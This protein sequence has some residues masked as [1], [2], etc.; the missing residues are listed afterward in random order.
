MI[1]RYRQATIALG[2]TGDSVF[3]SLG[4]IVSCGVG[5]LIAAR[6]PARWTV[7]LFFGVEAVLLAIYRDSLLLNVLMLACP[8][9]A[10]KSWQMGH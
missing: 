5:F 7:L 2:Y 1:E 8:I 4:D 6:L 9:E 3:N 10:V